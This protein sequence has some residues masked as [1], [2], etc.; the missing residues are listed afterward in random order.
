MNLYRIAFYFTSIVFGFTV[1]VF[2]VV[3][4]FEREAL[5]TPIGLATAVSFVGVSVCLGLLCR[6]LN[7]EDAQ[8]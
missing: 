5:W 2:T 1:C 3:F 4:V 8:S 7:K 6:K